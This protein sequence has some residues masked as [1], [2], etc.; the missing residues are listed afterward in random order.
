MSGNGTWEENRKLVLDKLEDIPK[1]LKTVQAIE[2]EL[3]KQHIRVSWI[4]GIMG[5]VG[6]ALTV[7]ITL[8][9]LL[10]KGII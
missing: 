5:L 3:T 10:L 2:I 8:G 9:I 6:G 4:S 7:S 1:I